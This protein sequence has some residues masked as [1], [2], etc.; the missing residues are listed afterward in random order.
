M[1]ELKGHYPDITRATYVNGDKYEFLLSPVGI[2]EGESVED[3]FRIVEHCI[4][5]L[6]KIGKTP[7]SQYLQKEGKTISEEVMKYQNQS[8]KAKN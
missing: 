7:K 8:P 2:D 5:F 3:R 4:D 1:K 6:E